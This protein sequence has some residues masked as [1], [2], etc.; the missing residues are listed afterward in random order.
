[1]HTLRS[2]ILPLYRR[3]D[4]NTL[5]AGSSPKQGVASLVFVWVLLPLLDLW[6]TFH[7]FFGLNLRRLAI[8]IVPFAT[9]SITFNVLFRL[10]GHLSLGAFLATLA[11]SLYLQFFVALLLMSGTAQAAPVLAAMVVLTLLAHGQYL[12]YTLRPA[13]GPAL[14]LLAVGQSLWFAP[15][16]QHIV[17]LCFAAAAGVAGGTMLGDV[18]AQT[19]D[20]R[21][22]QLTLREALHSQELLR[23]ESQINAVAQVVVKLF[24]NF[25]DVRNMLMATKLNTECL[26]AEVEKPA[27]SLPELREIGGDVLAGL[28]RV[29]QTAQEVRELAKLRGADIARELMAS[30]EQGYQAPATFLP[31]L[32]VLQEA[33][34]SVSS[35]FRDRTVK[36]NARE[37][38]NAARVRC[39]GGESTLRRV[40]EN[41]LTNAMEGDGK[42]SATQVDVAV[43]WSRELPWVEV[44][45]ADDGPGFPAQLLEG[46][47][48]S[49]S[50]TKKEG[51]GLGLFTC[52]R[53]VRACGGTLSR[54]NRAD[55]GALVVVRLP[56]EGG[57]A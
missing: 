39:V 33:R 13:I 30:E 52:D 42:A 10:A 47:V 16:D 14:S 18:M 48:R 19:D 32:P 3:A 2:L 37:D 27:P 1:M 38:A 26:L 45:V 28:V 17:V 21:R 41:L 51:T 40:F 35:R 5:S 29:E 43:S 57:Y 7:A 8:A 11:G 23:A 44:T 20:M 31:L 6:P 54:S 24:G 15:S 55:G 50:T 53:L 36:L 46:P 25:H 49:F 4:A 12:R 22:E 9:A 56:R 34:E